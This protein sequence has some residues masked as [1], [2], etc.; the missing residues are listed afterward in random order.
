MAL[1]F[2]RPKRVTA[3]LHTP[4]LAGLRMH[5]TLYGSLARR[6]SLKN[7]L[8]AVL[9]GL[10]G[11]AVV[12]LSLYANRTRYLPYLLVQESSG[13]YH[14]L[15]NPDPQWSPTDMM[16]QTDVRAL[17]Y[18]LRGILLDPTENTRRWERVLARVTERGRQQAEAAY[19]ELK[20]KDW[21][22]SIQIDLLT[23]LT[24]TTLQTYEILWTETRF[25]PNN[26]K[27]RSPEG[28]TRWRGIFTVKVDRA[29]AHPTYVPD[30]IVYDAWT[31]SR[32]E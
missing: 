1:R 29:L 5:E 31:I 21:R 32:E 11:Y 19:W 8:I 27:D 22:G 13:D 16:A 25:D 6:G 9:V 17:V 18:T 3:P 14:V 20:K 4:A 12:Q 26:D 10:L 30:G 7:L 28:F 23:V 2:A 15:S 24:R